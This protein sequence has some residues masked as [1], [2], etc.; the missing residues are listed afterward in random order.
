MTENEIDPYVELDWSSRDFKHLPAP[1]AKFARSLALVVATLKR[2]PPALRGPF[3][4]N[5]DL[6]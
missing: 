5:V 3:K 6:R 1:Q 2:T 4:I